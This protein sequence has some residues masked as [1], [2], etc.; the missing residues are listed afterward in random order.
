MSP[1]MLDAKEIY[2]KARRLQTAS[3][4]IDQRWQDVRAARRGDLDQVFPDLVSEE[5][6]K[7]IVANFIDTVARDLAEIV[8]PLPTFNCSS[9]TMQSDAAR[10]FA[11]KRTKIAMHYVTCSKLENQMQWGADHYFSYGIAVFYVEPDYKD[12]VPRIN[13]EEPVGGYP[14]FDRWG[15]IRT[16]TKRLIGDR[17]VIA[18]QFPEWADEIAQAA[19]DR[20]A[21]GQ[22]EV[23]LIRYLSADQIALVLVGQRPVFLVNV[24]NRLGEPPVAVA[25]RPWLDPRQP[26]GQFDDVLWMQLARDAL[27][28]LQ[29]EAAEKSVQAPLAL[30]N[31]VQ[32]ITTG[33]D[34]VLRTASPEKIRRVPMDINP[35]V[36]TE[37]QFLLEEMRQGTRYPQ[38]RTGHMDGSIVTGRGVQALMGGFDSQIKAAQS[39]FAVAL[40][41]VIRLCFKMDETFWANTKKSV[42]GYMA[43]TPYEI[44]YTPGRD[45]KGSHW[46]DVSYGFA[47][48]LDPNRAVVMLLQ[49]RAEKAF[50]RDFFQ[51]QLPF[52]FDVGEEN[53]KV[54]VEETREAIKQGVFAYV[55]SI[56]A[57]AQQGVDPSEAV[58]RLSQI[59]KGLRDG[60]A[61]EDVVSQAFAPT[62][63]PPVASPESTPGGP[64]EMAGGPGGM[65]GPGGGL[66]ESGLMRGVSPGQAG[67]PAGGRPDLS[68][69][70]AGLTG[71]GQPQMSNYVMKRRRV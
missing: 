48:G 18:N 45:I 42:R 26:K 39:A 58:Q 24:P 44:D 31:D 16:Y 21:P 19:K 1:S 34:A 60:K 2:D 61:I 38:A 27:A 47:S 12:K 14:E 40:A 22:T 20:A 29:L 51:R 65:G 13:V 43:G 36:F 50:S 23:E 70:L 15:R 35:G 9:S 56:P 68:V 71:N 52:D 5:W 41:D 11:D 8:A 10:K 46:V 32:E 49:L 17:E 63:P 54:D 6:P 28:K 53:R 30:P 33:P 57:M 7:P 37:S 3:S 64:G 55:Q 62:P 59:V 67:Q 25:Y 4:D 66:T 69:M